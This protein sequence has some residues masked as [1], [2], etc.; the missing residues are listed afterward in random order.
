MQVIGFHIIFMVFMVD[1]LL[2]IDSREKKIL[3]KDVVVFQSGSFI[4]LVALN[5]CKPK[6]FG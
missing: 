4:K 1:Y 6:T 5:I 2:W 3:C